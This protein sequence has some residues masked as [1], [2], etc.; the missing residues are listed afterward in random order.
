[1]KLWEDAR[2]VRGLRTQLEMRRKRLDGGDATLGWK[3]GFAAPEMLKRLDVS[4]PLIGFLTRK[5][6][7][8][9]GANVSLAG[10]AK[11]VAEPEIAVHVSRDVPAG[12]DHAAAEAAIAGISPAIEIVDVAEPPADPERILSGNIYQRHVVLAGAAPARAGSA[13]DGLVCRVLRRGREFARTSDPQANTGKWV[14]IVRH[15][16]DVLAAFGERLRGGEI[17]ITGSVVPPI[18][19]EPGEDAIAFAVDPFGAVDV[20]FSDFKQRGE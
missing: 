5:A 17:I 11:P 8:H 10:W 4:G 18:A 13:A 14:D 19:I 12:A 16:A 3:V 2:V 9:S 6:L 15:V 1:M 7:V 20:R